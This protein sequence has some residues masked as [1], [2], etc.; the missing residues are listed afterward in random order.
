MLNSQAAPKLI[1][2]SL[3]LRQQLKR[4][5]ERRWAQGAI[6]IAPSDLRVE[7]GLDE[8]EWANQAHKVRGLTLLLGW[9][10]CSRKI[11]RNQPAQKGFWPPLR[12]VPLIDDWSEYD[13]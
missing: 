12:P 11:N 1:H 7:L 5:L 13:D 9:K 8:R 6:P 4:L 2:K 10:E 3:G